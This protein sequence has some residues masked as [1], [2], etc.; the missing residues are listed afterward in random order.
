MATSAY[1]LMGSEF[2]PPP[3][4]LPWWT[5]DNAERHVLP[6]LMEGEL[7]KWIWPLRMSAWRWRRRGS[8]SP[9]RGARRTGCFGADLDR[10]GAAGEARTETSH[11]YHLPI[12]SDVIQVIFCYVGLRTLPPRAHT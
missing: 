7:G 5:A 8:A 12:V 4:T 9:C 11:G 10:D 6:A 2:P 1:T 3:W